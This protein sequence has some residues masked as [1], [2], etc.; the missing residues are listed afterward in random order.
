MSSEEKDAVMKAF[1]KEEYDIL[2]ST[3]VIE[4]G[5][6]VPN[7]TLMVIEHAERFG[8]FQLHQLRGR[9]GRGRHSSQCI[10]MVGDQV[11]NE[12]RE[13]LKVM[14][15][16]SSGFEIAEE[17]LRIRGPGDFLGTRQAGM[18]DFRYAHPMKDRELMAEAQR[19]AGELFREGGKLP[20]NL[21]KEVDKFWSDR[22]NLAS[23]G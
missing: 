14:I 8:L 23:S 4:V 22:F 17:D 12:A 9:V 11:S 18:P 2:V 15:R 13:R 20:D 1:R 19:A 10:L 6:D 5:V 7:A 16:S 3:T 21:V